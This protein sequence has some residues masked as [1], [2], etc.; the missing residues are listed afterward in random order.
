MVNTSV[1]S[2][3]FEIL[4]NPN[5]FETLKYL[6]ALYPETVSI[7]LLGANIAI[8]L[9]SNKNTMIVF[10]SELIMITFISFFIGLDV[11]FSKS[12][13]TT[14]FIVNGVFTLMMLTE[15][16]KEMQKP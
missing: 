6:L 13:S 3:D 7:I 1:V 4:S 8:Y 15:T 10:V 2:L 12:I 14:V 16:I 11:I 9:S 5:I